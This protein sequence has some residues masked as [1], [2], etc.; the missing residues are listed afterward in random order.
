MS[1]LSARAP[2][3]REQHVL[4]GFI[5]LLTSQKKIDS[6]SGLSIGDEAVI[7]LGFVFIGML[8]LN[9]SEV[10]PSLLRRR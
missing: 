9:Y 1:S 3:S 4:Q 7:K 10:I 2:S 6:K 5:S 8:V